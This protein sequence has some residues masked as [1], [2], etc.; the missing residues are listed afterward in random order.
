MKVSIENNPNVFVEKTNIV[1]YS[2]D[3]D[4]TILKGGLITQRQLNNAIK[5]L[6]E[7]GVLK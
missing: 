5:K 2:E 1:A 7:S 4:Y 3:G 6:K